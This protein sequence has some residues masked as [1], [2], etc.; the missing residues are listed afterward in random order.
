VKP[1]TPGT[2]GGKYEFLPGGRFHA[3]N[4][5]LDFLIQEIYGLRD[6]QVVGPHAMMTII[7]DGSNARYDIEATAPESATEAQMKEMVKT[8]LADRFQLKAH[9]ETSE[10]SVYALIPAKGGL[11]FSA[12]KNNANPR[13]RGVMSMARG[14]I[15]G[16]NVSMEAF[17]RNLSRSV[18]RPVIDK[19]AFTDG[20]DFR[21]T[22]TPDSPPSETDDSTA[23]RC[24]ANWDALQQRLGGG[25][26]P[27]NCPSLF[28]AIQE[29]L[30]LKLDPQKAPI[31]VLVIDHVEKPSEN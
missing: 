8:L 1:S 20:F 27:V 19:T 15:Q 17:I 4:V 22:W 12:S 25:A 2:I 6:Y 14:W 21:L 23:G 3:T 16:S 26:A 30:G 31:D 28:T 24:P 10:F 11:K 29:Q 5:P 18:D 13:S 7:A 9:R